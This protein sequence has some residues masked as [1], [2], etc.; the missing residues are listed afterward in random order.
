MRNEL[1]KLGTG[2][3]VLALQILGNTE[4]AADAV[5]DAMVAVLRKPKA[6]DPARG[7]L[8]PWFFRIVRNRALDLVRQRKVQM[9]DDNLLADQRGAPLE[10]A[11]V[12]QRDEALL[13]GLESLSQEHREILVLGDYAGLSYAEISQALE[14]PAGTVMSR[15]HRARLALRTALVAA[16]NTGENS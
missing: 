2:A 15:L 13:R 11:E 5:Q 14:I 7:A 3:Y 12:A 8:K 4:D 9:P 16:D 10:R 6:F 1:A